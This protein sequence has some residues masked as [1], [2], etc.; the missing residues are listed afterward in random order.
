MSIQFM[1]GDST[2]QKCKISDSI[3]PPLKIFDGKTNYMGGNAYFEE[4][5]NFLT[6][7]CDFLRIY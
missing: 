1:I 4:L 5:S 2:S 6:D 3:F 7:Q